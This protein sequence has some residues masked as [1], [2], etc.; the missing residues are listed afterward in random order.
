[1]TPHPTLIS[2]RAVAALFACCHLFLGYFAFAQAPATGEIEGRVAH[3]AAGEFLKR[4]HLRVEGTGLEAYTDADGVYRLTGVP[5]GVAT[6]RVSFAGLE[7]RSAQVTVE[8]G[9]V[10]V[11]NFTLA[12]TRLEAASGGEVVT[13]QEFTVTEREL[14]V[15]AAA[16]QEQRSA[17]NLK[18][19]VAFEEFG[20]L[21]E[22]NVGEFLKFVPGVQIETGPAVASS[23]I[24]RGMPASGTLL[25]VDGVEIA[26]D[27]P[28]AR[29]ASFSSTNTS[30]VDRVEITKVPTPDLPANAVGGSI[31]IIGKNGFSRS[32]PQLSYN[33]FGTLTTLDKFHRF[34]RDL[35]LTA[36]PDRDTRKSHTRPGFDL[37]YIHPFNQTLAISV[38]A[39]HSSRLDDRDYLT[40]TWNRVTGI[41]T[42]SSVNAVTALRERSI[43]SAR[44]DWK[45]AARHAL[46]ATA[47]YST[48]DNYSRQHAFTQAYGAGATGGEFFTQGA[49]TGVGTATQTLT[50]RNQ[51]KTTRAAS[52][53]HRYEGSVW[54]ADWNVGFSNARR[55]TLSTDEGFFGTVSSN[56]TNLV[57]RGEGLD[58]IYSRMPPQLTALDRAG[59]PVDPYNTRVYSINT[60]T[61]PDEPLMTNTVTSLKGNVRRDFRGPLPLRL[62]AGASLL[63]S[64]RDL[65]AATRTWTFTPPGGAAGRIA[66]NFDV[67]NEDYS[68]DR[69]FKGSPQ[70]LWVNPLEVYRLYQQQPSYF[71]PNESAGHISQVQGSK[72]LKETI[73]AGYLRADLKLLENRLWLVGGA[74]FE[75]TDD[76]G[77]GPLNDIRATY[78][79][80]ANGNLIRN[81]AGQP[82]RVPGDALALARLQYRERASFTDRHYSDLYPSFNSSYSLTDNVVVRAAYA[83]TIGRPDLGFVIPGTAI[84]DPTVADGNRTITVVN[85]GLNPWTADN[86]DLSL[87]SYSVK[88]ATASVSLFRKDIS[89]FF[90]SVRTDATPELLANYGLSDDYLDYDVI[91]TDNSPD[92]VALSGV[93]LSWRQSLAPWP[94]VPAWAR[95]TQVFC[96]VTYY[97]LSGTG[98]DN[99]A[100][101]S[102]RNVNWGVAYTNKR[103][104]GKLN[105]SQTMRTRSNPEAVS[106]TTPPETY[107]AVDFRLLVD[108][109]FE[110]RFTKR[111]AL[112]GSARN[113][114]GYPK[115][116]ITHSPN[117]PA[118]TRPRNYQFYGTLFTFGVKGV[119]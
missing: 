32:R 83:R 9:R 48:D 74:R 98:R 92:S 91:T 52:L 84:S 55:R 105:V 5:A 42:Q 61:A 54:Q 112:Y 104:L 94:A 77:A 37:T 30:N 68:G 110:F 35:A 58:G 114:N 4:A 66:G 102:P 12:G 101:Y 86:Y 49:A 43:L 63:R 100:G 116:N 107:Q 93:E 88:G 65:R 111:Y 113:L 46:F 96:N 19:V 87:E 21:G 45:P 50:Y 119:F 80:D 78:Q 38:S 76:V 64:E 67:F 25:M 103:F 18:N 3:A 60:V 90:A 108:A 26:T 1:M 117:A 31:N 13:L 53:G 29:A 41:Q 40:P 89:N 81:A 59:A 22:G 36:G 62:A 8:A 71:V 34:G 51:L 73:S 72:Y 115:F 24:I 47:Q 39:G 20:D 56:L 2:R 70:V 27:S 82:V 118:Y 28:S 23:A 109:S 16:L 10:A 57:L 15:Q 44:V 14:S 97:R 7:G 75:R 106:A 85:A 33:V 95:G 99:F 79:Q 11:Q 17:P 69:S 6:L